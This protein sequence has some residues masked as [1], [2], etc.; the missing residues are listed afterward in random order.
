MKPAADEGAASAGVARS[1]GRAGRRSRVDQADRTGQANPAGGASGKSDAAGAEVLDPAV[2]GRVVSSAVLGPAVLLAAW[3]GGAVWWAVVTAASL[4]ALREAYNIVRAGGRRP[5]TWIGMLMV[6][7]FTS[8]F[9]APAAM[10]DLGATTTDA[11]P[12][13]PGIAIALAM[14]LT[15]AVIAAYGAQ[16]LR[17]PDQRSSEDWSM[18]LALALHVGP[19]A[20]FA[21]A[22]RALP[23]GMTWT[24]LALLL[25]WVNDSSA[26]V[27]GQML[28]RTPLAPALSPKKTREGLAAAT[29]ATVAVAALV[30]AALT[31][32]E[33]PW[34]T[35]PAMLVAMALAL[36][37]VAPLGDLAI[38]LLKRQA[39]VKDSG[40]LIPGHGG[41]L[42]RTDSLLF[43]VPVWYAGALWTILTG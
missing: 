31:A 26:Y 34:P 21:I 3:V 13:I 19:M 38:S 14:A 4:L 10:G 7:A 37:L 6:V 41:I 40:H 35:G 17:R 9:A 20:A 2:A 33:I 42:D 16:M 18:T 36:A 28:G 24:V 39:G 22:L 23:F 43:G 25:V 11:A 1:A 30:P 32:L 15:A 8:A 29:F 12:H 5:H 27:G